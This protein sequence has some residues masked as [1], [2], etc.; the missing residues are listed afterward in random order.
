MRPLYF[1]DDCFVFFFF[2]LVDRVFQVHSLYR[3]I[4]RD[5][6]NVHAVDVAELFFLG[7]GSTSHAALLL[8]FIEQVLECDG[9]QGL[10]LPAHLHVLLRLDRLMEAVGITASR[11]DT[12]CKLIDDHDLTLRCDHIVLIFEHQ[13][14]C[15]QGKDDIVLDLQVLRVCEVIDMEELLDLSHSVFRQVD[16]LFLLIY[17]EISCLLNVLAH[18]GVHLGEFAARLASLKLAGKDIA[19]FIELRRFPALPG[20]DQRRPR[21]IDQYRVHLIDDGKVKPS[22]HEL[23]FVDDHVVTQ[24]VESQLIIGHISNIAGISLTALFIVHAV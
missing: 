18:D 1:L 24:I 20:N 21:L 6:D 15:P 16:R 23:F 22:L 4:G 5:L 2:R 7:K 14:V 11:H 3:D 12:S 19:G 10:A 8:K 9:C 13:V 17:N